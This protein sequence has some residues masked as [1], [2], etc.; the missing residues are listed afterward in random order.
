MFPWDLLWNRKVLNWNWESESA[1]GIMHK[2]QH[3]NRLWAAAIKM[4]KRVWNFL[5][6]LT[7]LDTVEGCIN[8]VLKSWTIRSG[9]LPWCLLSC[10][11]CK[12]PFK[13]AFIYFFIKKSKNP[14]SKCQVS[15]LN[16]CN[17][18]KFLEMCLF[19]IYFLAYWDALGQI[20]FL[21]G[22]SGF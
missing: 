9:S 18:L 16:S 21:S 8:P 10:F 17:Y 22:H 14:K 20:E 12:L 19:S 15:V 11:S 5:P 3:L 2:L 1:F 6:L 13:L 4:R 7:I